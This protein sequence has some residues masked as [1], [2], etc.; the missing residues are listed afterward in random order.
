MTDIDPTKLPGNPMLP[1][2]EVEKPKIKTTKAVIRK[3]QQP[4]IDRI[5]G[6]ETARSIGEYVIWEVLIPA[7]KAT[8]SDIVT[9]TV[10]MAVYGSES[11]DR[12]GK[13]LRRERGQTV[14]SYNSIYDKQ[15][16]RSRTRE[17]RSRNRH[18]FDDILIAER[19][20]AE[21]ILST[22]IEYLDRYD[23]VTVADFYEACGL[24]SE[25]TDRNYGWENLD[26]ASIRA[27]RGGW[28]VDLPD[29][30]PIN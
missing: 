2:K 10:E 16:S 15:S 30:Y 4:W 28:I 20:D 17:S 1:K 21:E 13:R 19:V 6:G 29:P 27:I 12:K 18:R 11:R 26:Q 9:N 23:L 8:I 24:P 5:F 7:A 3:R 25:Y 22:I 14:V